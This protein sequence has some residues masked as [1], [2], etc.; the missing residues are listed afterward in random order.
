M[1]EQPLV[2]IIT[3]TYNHERFIG[4]CIDS[5]LSQTYPYWEQIVIDDGSSD[6]TGDIVSQY[7]DSRIKYIRQDNQGI[8]KLGETYNRALQ[9][10]QGE[11]IAVLEGDDFWPSD[12]LERQIPCFEDSHVVLS[13]GREA[14]TDI[15]G[16]IISVYPKDIKGY[17]NIDKIK[18][19]K[20]LLLHNFIAASTAICRRDALSSIGG[21]RQPENTPFVDH[22]TWLELSLLGEFSAVDAVLGYWRRHSQQTSSIMILEMHTSMIEYS[23]VFF[24]RLPPELRDSIGF[25]VH[26]FEFVRQRRFANAFLDIGRADLIDARW[27]EAQNNFLKALV[28]G[29]FSIKARA[30][31]GL[32]CS[33]C[34]LDMEW[35]A[36]LLR[37]PSLK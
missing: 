29:S 31:L 1:L 17:R 3:A 5:V 9:L 24:Q 14:V 6:R 15:N 34:R 2:S 35:A 23:L 21:F 16:N 37:R 12:K 20:K 36:I 7:K 32:F 8:W 33:C 13:W 19:L 28:K 18:T 4:Q 25:S 22:P 30:L 26:D 11:L 10:S 27:K